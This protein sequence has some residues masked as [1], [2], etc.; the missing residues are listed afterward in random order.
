MVLGVEFE[1]ESIESGSLI[2]K[3]STLKLILGNGK[4]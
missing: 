4:K 3:K 1:G 2:P